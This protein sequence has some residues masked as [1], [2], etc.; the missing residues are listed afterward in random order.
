MSLTI[1]IVGAAAATLALFGAPSLLLK[2]VGGLGPVAR[3]LAGMV[4]RLFLVAGLAVGVAIAAPDERRVALLITIAA[5]YFAAAL[6][7]GVRRFRNRG[8]LACSAR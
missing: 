2:R 8:A 6:G 7:D 5:T 1:E 4:M 3:P